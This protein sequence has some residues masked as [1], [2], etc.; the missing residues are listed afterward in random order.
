MRSFTFFSLCFFI[1]LSP[2]APAQDPD[3]S[4]HAT[5]SEVSLDLVVRDKKAHIIRNLRPE[6]V[7][8]FE[9]GVRQN[10]R[11]FEFVGRPSASQEPSAP[12]LA[13]STQS[14]PSS[15]SSNSYNVQELREISVVSL[16]VE[17]LG[18]YDRKV[19]P[20]IMRDFLKNEM[21]PNTYVG[22]FWF[23][24]M[25]FRILQPYTNDPQRISAAVDRLVRRPNPGQAIWGEDAA[26]L[27]PAPAPT[28]PSA[29]PVAKLAELDAIKWDNELHDVYD[30]SVHQL[31][32]IRSLVQALAVFP[33]RKVLLLVTGGVVVH[34]ETVELLKASISAANRANVTIYG[35][36]VRAF[37]QSQLASGR[38]LLTAAANA[39]A[40]QQ[41]SRVNGGDQTVTADEVVAGELAQA[42]LHAN[43]VENLAELSEATGGKLLQGDVE[44]QLHK[45]MEEIQAHYELTYSP[46]NSEA[47]GRFRNIEVKVSRPGAQVFTRTGY[48]ALPM[49]NGRQIYPFEMATLKA[50]NAKP[51]LRQFEFHAAAL[52]FRSG[53]KESQFEFVF[54][55]PARELAITKDGKWAKVHICVT[56]LIRNQQGQVVQKISK[57]IPYG[58]PA[59]K[60]ADLQR[61]VVSFTEPFLLP[62]GRYTLEAA[63][64]DRE[65]MK[66]SVRRSVLVV[67]ETAGLS[68]SDVT[69]V[70][71]VEITQGPR[72]A[73]D[74]LEAQGGKITPE[75]SDAVSQE[76]TGQVRFYAVAYAPAPVDTP[77]QAS[78][79]IWRD[80]K[81][82][83][84]TPLTEVPEEGDRGASILVGVPLEKLSPGEYG[85]QV[86]FQY[87]GQTVTR[88]TPFTVAQGK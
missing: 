18:E 28:G 72:D 56:A 66:A 19:L 37:E 51:P 11:H 63:T 15:V 35:I 32:A 71:R 75:L 24:D 5:A 4:L 82:V 39:S 86:S 6:E 2:A 40:K 41:M 64:V 20:G 10:L 87:Q 77:I 12:A 84:R 44:G 76:A 74:P 13:A 52:Q 54:Q 80:G 46:V 60:T 42:S 88:M 57:D 27:P 48:Y 47:D 3:I 23:N 38:R 36:D 62:P 69:M 9:D 30:N 68:M 50:L 21:R 8:V 79:E 67:G 29:G 33:G 25:S 85:A 65:S 55:T 61:G 83:F 14:P 1:A 58:V 53:Q 31:T 45:A 16:V 34:P 49:L 22:V 59:D 78:V 26:A 70:R 43:S 81:T 17:Q 7:Q 73:S